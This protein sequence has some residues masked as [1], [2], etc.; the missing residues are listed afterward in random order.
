MESTE[1]KW[2]YHAGTCNPH[3][4]KPQ[5]VPTGISYQQMEPNLGNQ[6]END[7]SNKRN[8]HN[9]LRQ[10]KRKTTAATQTMEMA[11][12]DDTKGETQTGHY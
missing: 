5:P 1:N 2:H 12:S 10:P 9:T 6:L 7:T 4:S 8:R 3:T 11:H